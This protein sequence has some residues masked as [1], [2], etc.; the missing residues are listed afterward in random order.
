MKRI[1]LL[2]VVFACGPALARPRKPKPPKP[3]PAAQPAPPPP[4]APP[5]AE[6]EAEEP[7]QPQQP[8]PAPPAPAPTPTQPTP[9]P[10]ER[11]GRAKIDLESL[12]A[13]Y[14]ALKD[15][16]FRSRAKVELLGSAL[17]KT[18]LVAT[19]QYKA[20]RAWPLKK[21][22]LRVDDQPVYSAD[23][24]DAEDPIKIYEGFAA[25]GRHALRVTIEAEAQGDSRLGYQT[26]STFVFDVPD[27]RQS[28]L[29]LVADEVGDGPQPLAKKKEGTFDVRVKAKLKNLALNAK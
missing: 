9:P 6:P 1:L 15:E 3:A 16:L 29:E 5:P 18:Q 26:E 27:G 13:E 17:Y 22:T 21:V 23:G 24:P 4:E 11:G 19:F 12:N 25:P 7:A 20:Q 14:Q 28:R 10:A 2:L 8:Q